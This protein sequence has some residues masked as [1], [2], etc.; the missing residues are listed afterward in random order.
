MK[1]I[2]SSFNRLLA[3]ALVLMLAFTAAV[4]VFAASGDNLLT[5]TIRNNKG[6]PKMTDNQFAAYQL[7]KGTPYQEDDTEHKNVTE[8]DW[9]AS[10]W[11]NYTLAD[12]EWGDGV[13]GSNLLSALKAL[14]YDT[15][16]ENWSEFFDA[17]KENA[18]VFANI[19][20]AAQL[21]ELLVGKS[22]AFLQK[23]S[24]FVVKGSGK[25]DSSGFLTSSAAKSIVTEETKSLE[26]IKQQSII[27]VNNPGYYL[28]VEE[29]DH[30]IADAVSEY[31][32][33]VLGNQEIDL[34][35]SAP[36]VDKNIVSGDD[37]L[38]GDVAGISDTVTF[39][40]TG[41]LSKNFMDFNTYEYIFT[42]TLSKGLTYAGN[43]VV[44]VLQGDVTY[45]IASS[46][47]T[48]TPASANTDEV[49]AADTLITVTFENL[50]KESGL[51]F[52]TR[53]PLEEPASG[54][55][56]LDESAKIYVTYDAVV[57]ENAVIGSVGNPNDVNLTYSNDPN[58]NDK[59]KT[60][61]KR[62][63]VY[64]FGLDLVKVGSD[65]AHD[66]EGLPGAGF[67]LKNSQEKY[68]QFEDATDSEGNAIRRLVNW[69]D[70]STV[71]DLISQYNTAKEAYNKAA[72]NDE[73]A[74]TKNTLDDKA[75][76]L[77]SYLLTSKEKGKIPNVTGLDE[78]KYTLTEII[79]PDGYNTMDPFWFQIRA[80]FAESGKLESVIYVPMIGKFQTYTATSTNAGETSPGAVFSSGLLPE[81]LTN[82]KA[83]FLPFTGGMG[84]IL[85]YIL[86]GLLIAGAVI[87]IVVSA[88]K[89]NKKEENI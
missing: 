47:Y 19:D 68:A 40:L 86:G 41:D 59:G 13:N 84:I 49:P 73:K 44:T 22:N 46:E 54:K 79:T 72:N 29:G 43:M 88:K 23:F 3:F 14:S 38:K 25:E 6:L 56:V 31:I 74:A 16:N 55:I 81:T 60:E 66:D 20:S 39:E 64:A 10:N 78:G 45:T 48:V 77:E 37:L 82:I 2:K 63:Y 35:A 65:A 33:A 36:T 11:N 27:Q 69:V 71:D 34:K 12:I 42:D 85:F 76:A 57:N 80:T 30:N 61:D 24:K 21:A 32:L 5:I 70:A 53:N 51:S 50:R 15:D 18:N 7:F 26:A 4:P 89:R 28:I 9:N 62:V 58:T 1:M 52:T 83:P 67:T 87:Y 17:Y 75:K 8:N